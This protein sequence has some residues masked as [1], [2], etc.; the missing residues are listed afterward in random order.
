MTPNCHPDGTQIAT[1]YVAFKPWK[2][3]VQRTFGALTEPFVRRELHELV[4]GRFIRGHHAT[5]ESTIRLEPIYLLAPKPKQPSVPTRRAFLIAGGTFFAGIG[6][7]GACGYAAGSARSDGETA[8]D[9]LM[10]TGDAD[11][12]ELRRLAIE[13]PIEELTSQWFPFLTLLHD[14]YQSDEVLWQGAKRICDEAINNE[15]LIDRSKIARWSITVITSGDRRL[16]AS[17]RPLLNE[18]RRVR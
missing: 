13:A 1:A 10:P 3:V 14:T 6:L 17:I 2:K 15:S 8:A 16:T 4:S 7:G 9:A 11:L 5:G 12:D 18:L